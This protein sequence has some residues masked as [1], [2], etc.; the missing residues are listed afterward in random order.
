MAKVNLLSKEWCDLIFEG[1][2][3]SY[4]A[5]QL[6][7]EIGG[8]YL[9]ALAVLFAVTVLVILVPFLIGNYLV[10]QNRKELEMEVVML[11]KLHDLKPKINPGHELKTIAPGKQTNLKAIKNAMRFVPIVTDDGEDDIL[12]GGVVGEDANQDI[13]K[14][15][16]NHQDGSTEGAPGDEN[17]MAGLTPYDIVEEMPQFPGGLAALMKWLDHTIV[18]PPDCIGK[19]IEGDVQ[20]SFIVSKEGLVIEPKIVKSVHPLLDRE[21]IVAV[22]KMPKWVPGRIKGK[23]SPVRITIPVSFLLN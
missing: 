22:Q 10:E 1:K 14:E 3:K 12:L 5:Y 17:S 20:V 6:R 19:R 8:R 18:Y 16:V 2:N 4:G 15:I 21:A 7:A 11:S 9:K 13:T 23:L